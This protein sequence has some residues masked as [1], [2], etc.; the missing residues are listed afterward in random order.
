MRTLIERLRE[1][2][3]TLCIMEQG[4]GMG[5]SNDMMIESGA[6]NVVISA[7]SWYSKD[8]C[9]DEM[10]AVSRE[11]VN[12]LN[13]YISSTPIKG[14]INVITSF[15]AGA[16]KDAHGYVLISN[17]VKTITYHLTFG[18]GRSKRQVNNEMPQILKN[19]ILRFIDSDR[20]QYT[21]H[22]YIDG[23]WNNKGDFA[24]SYLPYN[25]G[26][27]IINRDKAWMRVVDYIRDIEELGIIKGSFNPLHDGH[28]QLVYKAEEHHKSNVL[29]SISSSS[30]EGK[31]L[32]PIQAYM[33]AWNICNRHPVLVDTGLM[34]YAQLLRFLD[35][36]WVRSEPLV[37]FLPMGVDVY[38]KLD[39]TKLDMERIHID[40]FT[41][42]SI[43]V[44]FHLS[45]H[46]ELS[47]TKIREDDV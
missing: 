3:Q 34:Y 27:Y 17:E 28:K 6:S 14:T 39:T 21:F 37:Y 35:N 31:H 18:Y 15:Q 1:K 38:S 11:F 16:S 9:P 24:P 40:V 10:R 5:F 19:L 32:D 8:L 20:T 43:G 46:P 4:Y 42:E 44:K 13:N 2:K 7:R 23:A 22:N 30:I 29:M 36:V 33:R 41:R 26:P 45:E 47:S 12:Y 25:H